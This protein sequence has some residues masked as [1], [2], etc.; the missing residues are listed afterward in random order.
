MKNII[1]R[2]LVVPYAPKLENLKPQLRKFNTELIFKHRDKLSTGN[3]VVY[4]K[5]QPLLQSG[6]CLAVVYW[7]VHL[8]ICFSIGSN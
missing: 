5:P 6:V 4:N 3:Q 8:R 2:K 1:D 7:H